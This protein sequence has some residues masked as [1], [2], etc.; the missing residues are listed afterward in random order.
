M[1]DDVVDNVITIAEQCLC[2]DDWEDGTPHD[3]EQDKMLHQLNCSERL[4]VIPTMVMIILMITVI[5]M[6]IDKVTNMM[7]M[8]SIYLF[9]HPCIQLSTISASIHPS[10]HQSIHQCNPTL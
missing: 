10:I 9:I 1:E 8:M 2:E 7:M 4:I 3:D 5:M 6:M